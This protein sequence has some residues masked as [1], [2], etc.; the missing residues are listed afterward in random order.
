MNSD[1]LI[2]TISNVEGWLSDHEALLLFFLAELAPAQGEIVEIGSWKGK[3]TICLGE[4][5][6]RSE[7]RGHIYAVD[8]HQGFIAAGKKKQFSQ[9]YT[10]FCKNIKSKGVSNLVEPI[11]KTSIAAAK[12]WKKSIRLLFIDGLHDYDH[13][14]E[15]YQL[16][17]PHVTNH[18]II[19]FHDGFCGEN[20]VWRVIKEQVLKREDLRDMGTVGS[21]FFFEIGKPGVIQKLRVTIKKQIVLLANILN[22]LKLPSE[23]KRILIHKLLRLGLVTPYTLAVYTQN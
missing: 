2:S 15:D 23:L 22:H 1:E 20:G 10:E 9:T 19:A 3:S 17:S 7:K 16:W 6:R 11:R 12:G 8:P 14:N 18:G 21:I 5:L 4:G 13:A